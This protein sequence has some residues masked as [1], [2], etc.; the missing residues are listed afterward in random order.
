MP[1]LSF[2]SGELLIIAYQA[3]NRAV[4]DG[5]RPTALTMDSILA[6]VVAAAAAEA[7]INELADH[8]LIWREAASDW[9]PAAVSAELYAAALAIQQS[10]SSNGSVIDKYLLASAQLPGD[11]LTKGAPPFQEFVLLS[12]LRDAIM[13][14]KPAHDEDGHAGTQVTDALAQRGIA[15]KLDPNVGFSW[16]NRIEVPAVA[17]WACETARAIILALLNQIP[18][19]T[20]DRDAVATLRELFRN[21]IVFAD[22]H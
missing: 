7:F 6:V 19:G 22:G 13:H 9:A 20:L 14:T 17:Q 2:H 11:R 5:N 8:A 21:H 10:E 4:I 16:F 3:R 18:S 1:T 12:R 15:I